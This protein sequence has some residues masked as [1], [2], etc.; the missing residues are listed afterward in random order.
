[1]HAKATKAEDDM[2]NE[3]HGIGPKSMNI[4]YLHLSLIEKQV[5]SNSLRLQLTACS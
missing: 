5:E 2:L 1:M 3:C 4:V